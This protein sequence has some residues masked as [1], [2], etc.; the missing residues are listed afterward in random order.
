MKDYNLEEA[1]KQYRDE[2]LDKNDNDISKYDI[3]DIFMDGAKWQYKQFENN[4]LAACDNM[5][6]EEAEREQEFTTDFIEKNNRIP[7]YSDAIEYGRESMRERL[8]KLKELAD[9]MY[10]AAQYLTTDA[11]KL[12]K[13]M[14]DY[15][16]YV[17][18]ELK[19]GKQ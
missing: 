8:T 14:R 2:F 7:T 15:W 4:I 6:K 5:T 11:S 9:K 3:E 17:I 18:Y 10:Y 16:H 1:A 13:A 12:R 19:E